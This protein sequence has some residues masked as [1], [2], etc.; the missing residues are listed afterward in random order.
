MKRTAK[1]LSFLFL[2]S[3][4]GLLHQSSANCAGGVPLTE[5]TDKKGK[6]V[7]LTENVTLLNA[8]IDALSRSLMEKI[9]TKY[10]HIKN[11]PVIKIAVFDFTD[12][13]GNITVGSRYTANR[14]G[15]AFGANS[16]FELV[17]LKK[18]RDERIVLTPD[19]FKTNQNL[20]GRVVDELGADVYILGEIETTAMTDADCQVTLWGTIPPHHE[21]RDLTSFTL[22]DET[23]GGAAP[24]Q[25]KLNLT[26]SGFDFFTSVLVPAQKEMLNVEAGPAVAEVIFLTQPLC[27]D[28]NP[29]WQIK[30]DGLIYDERK[31]EETGF[32]GKKGLV[33]QSRVK[34]MESLKEMNYVIKEFSLVIKDSSGTSVQLVPYVLPKVSD[35]YFIPFEKG[36]SGLRFLYLWNIPGKT[37]RESPRETGMGWNFKEAEQDW[38]YPC[39][40]GLYAVTATLKPLVESDFGTKLEKAEFVTSFKIDVKKGRNI[41]VINYAYRVDRPKVFVR[42]LEIE[43]TRDVKEKDTIRKITKVYKVYGD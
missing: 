33:M 34:G 16:Q 28:L 13:E 6:Q 43:G 8:G 38:P 12:R 11:K 3:L 17:S 32:L 36:D 20:R 29:Y 40:V 27:D 9:A 37:N 19:S 42:R 7:R 1:L 25:W 2:V 22:R 15:L 14:I 41:Y 23:K 5:D 39:Q 30:G 35:Y 4:L 21:K 31:K 24:L 18:I 10:F 26:K